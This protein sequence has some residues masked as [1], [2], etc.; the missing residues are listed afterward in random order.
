MV[1]NKM[2]G[3]FYSGKNILLTGCTGFVGKVLLEK[4]LYSLPQ[5]NKIYVL[6]RPKKGSSIE[7]R[8]R[9][10]ILDSPCYDRLKFKYPKFNLFIQEK[11]QPVGGDMLKDGL[12]LTEQDR[13]MLVH[14]LHVIINCAASVDFNQRLDQAL[15]INTL[16]SLRVLELAKA[17]KQLQVQ[18]QVSTAYVNCDKDAWIDEAIYPMNSDP[19]VIVNQLLQ[20]PVE[21][22]EAR[23]PQ[24]LG[25][26]PN[27]YTFTK[28]LTEHMIL[29]ERAHVRCC[30]IR[31]TII[32]GSWTEPTPGWV[33]SIAA[34]GAFYLTAGLGV[35]KSSHGNMTHIGD[36]IPVDFVCNACIVAGYYYST[37]DEVG[38][39]HV[40]TSARNPV[41]WR[42]C[43]DVI[44]PYWNKYPPEK[45]ISKCN[46]RMYKNKTAFEALR[47]VKRKIPAYLFLQYAKYINPSHLKTAT[48]I[49]K[50]LQREEMISESFSHFTNNEWI[51]AS[52]KLMEMAKSLA[53][54]EKSEFELD[55][56]RINW[57]VCILNYA[58]GLHKFVLKENVERPV[59]PS[60][61]ELNWNFGT[62]KYF[63][64][65]Y[66]AY[67][68]GEPAQVRGFYEMKSLIFNA[69]SVQKVMR[70]LAESSAKPYEVALK[71]HTA[72]THDILNKLCSDMRTPMV[73]LFGWMLRK[74]YRAIY[75]KV[76]VDKKYLKK[77]T[78]LK[79]K[80]PGPVLLMPTHRSYIDFLIVSYVFFSYKMRVPFIAAGEDFLQIRIV[81]HLLRMSGAFFIRRRMVNDP[82]YQA[83]LKEYVQQL[84]KDDQM[85]EFF[86]EG[87]RSR[88]GKALHPKMG[89]LSMCT[90]AYFQG[91]VPNLNIVPITISYERVL[92]GETFPFE[93][94]GEEKTKES[95][96]RIVKAAKI[97]NRNFGKIYVNFCEPLS[98]KDYMKKFPGI[99]T[100]LVENKRKINSTLA[101]DLIFKLQDNM[102]IMPTALV[103]TILLMHRRSLSE[104]E[105]I[106]K[107]EWL[108]DELKYRGCKIGGMNGGSANMAVRS[109]LSHLNQTVKY[110]KDLLEPSV[111]IQSDYK[112][113]L[114]LSYYRNN[115][116]H[117]FVPDVVCAAAIYSFGDKIAWEEGV[118]RTR[119]IEETI[120]LGNLV[121]NYFVTR[122]KFNDTNVVNSC[123]DHM[124]RREILSQEEDKIKINRGSDLMITFLCSM[125][126]PI[127]DSYWVTTLFCS[128]LKSQL[129]LPYER[130]VQSVRF[131]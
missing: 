30:I 111:T 32:G 56:T 9:K 31:P 82:L 73:R 57:K 124:I 79:T 112:N 40:G 16:G 51:F 12:A 100:N 18:V 78:K 105:L 23:T 113:I 38:V 103:A 3:E 86:L 125:I 53:K 115:L 116:L 49:Q 120:F 67:N 20:I 62:G 97:L 101:Y 2:I 81:S 121:E 93:L 41:T 63:S 84:V 89:L 65:I 55:V 42:T 108:R 43:R 77:I 25:K 44:V 107:V 92:E 129:S 131:T 128:A 48:R 117:I 5:V 28:N 74:I 6:V 126:W 22:I 21:E 104:D 96:S 19:A 14:S 69:P 94:L 87:T 109:A 17:C 36:Q 46:F 34:A 50:L 75:E 37:R 13:N 90:D 102:V 110:K 127:I 119:L 27:T 68:G 33:D 130:L 91:M 8:F 85:L 123:F 98:F 26:Y 11:V 52:E 122:F 59:D 24:I 95:L 54:A 35:L 72:K 66:W 7:E 61:L 80:S 118:P 1:V 29:R 39:V 4:F 88:T 99:D 45:K 83:I 10:E 71:E 60:S 106:T 58:F 15:Q 47:I 70:E 114:L 64:D 76:V